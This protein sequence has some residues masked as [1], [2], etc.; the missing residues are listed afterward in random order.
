MST[1]GILPFVVGAALCGTLASWLG[2][3]MLHLSS[4]RR[5]RTGSR[6]VVRVGLVF[7][8]ARDPSPW[9][10]LHLL[11]VAWPLL[12]SLAA[13]VSFLRVRCRLGDAVVAVVR[14]LRFS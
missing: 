2:G 11:H 4:F 12:G 3:V 6:R 14:N 8:F 10:A 7:F 1:S 5:A 9:Q 13:R